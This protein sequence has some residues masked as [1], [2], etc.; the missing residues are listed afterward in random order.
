MAYP[1]GDA[2]AIA[3]SKSYAK[4]AVAELDLNNISKDCKQALFL[5]GIAY[6]AAS[7]HVPPTPSDTVKNESR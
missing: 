4:R 5:L 6:T 1:H 3:L 2:M 7:K